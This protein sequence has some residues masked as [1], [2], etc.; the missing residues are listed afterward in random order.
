MAKDQSPKTTLGQIFSYLHNNV[1]SINNSK[2]FAGLMI[3]TLNVVSKFVNIKLSKTMEAYLKFSFSKQILVFAIA[4]MGTRDI[5][6]ALFITF[7][8]VVCS[9][10]FFH[11][12]SQFFMLSE[13]FKDYHI[14]LLDNEELNKETVTEE[15]IRKAKHILKRATELNMLKDDK[16]DFQGYSLK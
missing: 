1:Q 6:I 10:Y 15:D 11:E 16:V 3:I 2:I 9:E 14:S 8:F 12:E 13:E 5:Y 4:W 7:L